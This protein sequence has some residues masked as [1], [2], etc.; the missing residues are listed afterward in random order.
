MINDRYLIVSLCVFGSG[1]TVSAEAESIN[2][3]KEKAAERSV[4]EEGAPREVR[5]VDGMTLSCVYSFVQWV[6]CGVVW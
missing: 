2:S 3:S 6:W 1:L 5:V 4:E